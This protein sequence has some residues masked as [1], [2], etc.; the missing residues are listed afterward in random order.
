MNKYNFL[1]DALAISTQID[2]I[3]MAWLM[4]NLLQLD[5]QI[6]QNYTLQ[7]KQDSFDYQVFCAIDENE[8]VFRL[9]EHK[10]NGVPIS[11]KFKQIDYFLSVSNQ[12]PPATLL[13]IQ[14]K[15]RTNKDIQA[16]F[17]IELC[18][19]ITKALKMYEF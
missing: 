1:T 12:C 17:K 5:F 9:I 14:N 2:T 4:G 11:K 3:R 16:V 18:P 6:D 15:L 8:I 19:K 13:E 7:N 10:T